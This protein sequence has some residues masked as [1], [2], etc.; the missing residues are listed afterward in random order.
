[1]VATKTAKKLI[2]DTDYSDKNNQIIF[3]SGNYILMKR[4]KTTCTFS[5]ITQKSST[6]I[7]FKRDY[8]D[9]L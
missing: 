4:L 2:Q 1:M 6:G 9:N 5:K 7:Y 8:T 3:D